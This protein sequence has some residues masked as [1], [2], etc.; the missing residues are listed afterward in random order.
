VT[1][2][3]AGKV[4]L[5]AAE[6]SHS[7]PVQPP[8][9]LDLT[10]SV[11]RR[12]STNLV[13]VLT[14][15]GEYV[16]VLAGAAAPAV[17]RAHQPR[18]DELAIRIVGDLREHPRLLA[19]VGRM[20]GAGADLTRFYRSASSIPW[21]EPLVLR[22]RGVRP[23]RYPTLWEAC[24]NAIVFQQVSLAAAS[25][26]MGR[27]TVSFGKAVELG[28]VRLYPFPGLAQIQAAPDGLLREA[29][30][31]AGKLAT[32]RRV[33]DALEGGVLDEAGLEQLPSAGAAALLRTVKGIGPWTAAVILLRGLGR[34]DVF[35][36]NDTSVARNLTLVGGSAPL[37]VQGVLEA[38]GAER[39]MLYYHLLLARLEARGDL[40]PFAA[41]TPQAAAPSGT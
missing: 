23:P 25:A 41:G 18:P 31:S 21:L 17:V 19:L 33:G 2:G 14:P 36:A 32:L 11:L 30:L 15:D 3:P 9:R 27:L 34:L 10:V 5:S 38:L 35:P 40:G 39:G 28:G 6:S 29:G 24:V 7:I 1:Q 4:R 22:M 8:Y 16:R 26:I 12:L 37:D 13:D 20:L